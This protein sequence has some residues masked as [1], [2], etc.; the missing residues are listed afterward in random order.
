MGWKG[1]DGETLEDFNVR[2][3]FD[4]LEDQNLHLA[5]QLA[6][7]NEDL[8]SFYDRVNKQNE[9]LKG[10]LNNFDLSKLEEIERQRREAGE[11]GAGAEGAGQGGAG[12]NVVSTTVNLGGRQFKFTGRGNRLEQLP[13]I[14]LQIGMR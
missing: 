9:D 1:E 13:F 10:M 4:K 3:L 6:R 7:H 14:Q 2:V 8:Q 5:S 11:S 12:T